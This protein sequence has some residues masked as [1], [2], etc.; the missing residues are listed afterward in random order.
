[1]RL[2]PSCG[3]RSRGI[4][5]PRF[6]IALGIVF[7]LAG[8]FG[9]AANRSFAL[10]AGQAA[11]Q[12]Q[13]TPAQEKPEAPPPDEGLIQVQDSLASITLAEPKAVAGALHLGL[14]KETEAR[15]TEAGSRLED[16]GDLDGDRAPELVLLQFLAEPGSAGEEPPAPSWGLFLLAWDGAQWKASR[17][18]DI[19][20]SCQ[21]QIVKSSRRG[22]R[23]IAVVTPSGDNAR[24]YPAVYGVKSHAATLLWDGAAEDS[25]YHGLAHSVFRF[26]DTGTGS[27]MTVTGRAD[28]GVLDFAPGGRRGFAITEDYRWDGRAFIPGQI[29]YS[30]NPDYTLYRFIAALHLRDFRAAYALVDPAPFMK[31]NSP[32]VDTFRQYV[33]KTWPEFLDDQIFE[34]RETRAT[35]GGDYAF[36]LP[37][38]HYLYEPRFSS[39]GKLIIGLERRTEPAV[40]DE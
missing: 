5:L 28:P 25:R 21:L 38:K 35:S 39:D 18:G 1:M 24:L 12:T 8:G 9:I 15:C 22:Q 10:P 6:P 32:T 23:S 11:P 30:A 2:P 16:F 13:T 20:E 37:E 19:T 3:V 7:G 40:A 29:R 14:H 26:R 27:E 33:E 36:T 17:L 34:A 31:T 4:I